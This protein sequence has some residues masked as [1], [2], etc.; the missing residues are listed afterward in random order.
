M[1]DCLALAQERNP[2]LYIK[3]EKP[4]HTGEFLSA[5]TLT[6]ITSTGETVWLSNLYI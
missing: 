5:A 4:P 2:H 1:S 3:W 6:C